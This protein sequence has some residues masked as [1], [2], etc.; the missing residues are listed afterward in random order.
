[1]KILIGT[2]L[3]PTLSTSL[4]GNITSDQLPGGCNSIHSLGSD[5]QS[6]FYPENSASA[7]RDQESDY[8]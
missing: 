2:E 6:V 5:I 3:A 4:L 1:M 7:H 8:K